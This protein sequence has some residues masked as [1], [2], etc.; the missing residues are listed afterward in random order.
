MYGVF[1]ALITRS[2]GSDGWRSRV[3]ARGL[4]VVA[5]ISCFGA[6]DEWHQ[7][8]IPGRSMELG[9]WIADTTGALLGFLFSTFMAGVVLR[10]RDSRS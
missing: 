7:Q 6:L 5:A 3:F 1:G 8:F 2:V 10:R 4:M 9:D